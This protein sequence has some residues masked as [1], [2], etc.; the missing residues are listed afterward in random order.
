M[1]KIVNAMERSGDVKAKTDLCLDGQPMQL[2]MIQH[3][4]QASK[5]GGNDYCLTLHRKFTRNHFEKNSFNRMRVFL[6]VQITSQGSLRLLRD[7]LLLQ[8]CHITDELVAPFIKIISTL[9]RL[10]DIM[11]ARSVHNGVPKDGRIIHKP[12]HPH[13]MELLD[14]LKIFA[15]WK[16]EAD[17]NKE[18][19]ITP[20]SYEDMTWMIY[21]V[22]GVAV[23]HLSDDGSKKMDQG[24]FGSDVCENHFS[25]NR[26]KYPSASLVDCEVGTANSQSS[27]THTFSTKT[28]SNT[29]GSRKETETE[30][31]AQIHR[32]K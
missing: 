8:K 29:S 11:N 13:L 23:T 30:I 32:K 7:K 4:W 5:D 9:D 12:T 28:G 16:K 26:T 31:F 15:A 22:I 27:R 6:A 21:A 1:K 20:E 10:V 14:T 19:F 2:K 3:L 17:S 24:R 18:H 25:N